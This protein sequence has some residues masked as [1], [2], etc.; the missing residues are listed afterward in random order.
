[1]VER[2][3]LRWIVGRIDGEID[4]GTCMDQQLD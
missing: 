2:L 4:G 1:M 3:W